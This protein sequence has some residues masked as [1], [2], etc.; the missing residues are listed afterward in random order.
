MLASNFLLVTTL[1]GRYHAALVAMSQLP[2]AA[3]ALTIQAITPLSNVSCMT[4]AVVK[5]T[6]SEQIIMQVEQQGH[7]R[8]AHFCVASRG[9]HQ[10]EVYQR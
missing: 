4:Q 3:G 8:V 1:V 9:P 5:H 6:C 10:Q 7:H 2:R